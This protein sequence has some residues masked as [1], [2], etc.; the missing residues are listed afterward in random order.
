[1]DLSWFIIIL[2]LILLVAAILVIRRMPAKY[3][4]GIPDQLEQLRRE[5]GMESEIARLKEELRAE[6]ERLKAEEEKKGRPIQGQSTPSD[7]QT[8]GGA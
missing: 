1:M 6:I 2:G 4:P 8:A 7:S 3:G 5:K